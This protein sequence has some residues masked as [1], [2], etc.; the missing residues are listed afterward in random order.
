M[1]FDV[2]L[3]CFDSP[4]QV[5]SASEQVRNALLM[6]SASVKIHCRK[7]TSAQHS[8]DAQLQAIGA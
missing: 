4:Q 3:K 8:F 7:A 1:R 2:I 5:H 6:R